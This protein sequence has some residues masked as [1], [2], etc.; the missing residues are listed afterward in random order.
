MPY[1]KQQ[2]YTDMMIQME[3]LNEDNKTLNKTLLENEELKKS[4]WCCAQEGISLQEE[5]KEL[6]KSQHTLI[7]KEKIKN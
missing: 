4:V 6:K 5:N 7:K 3:R 1:I 2:D